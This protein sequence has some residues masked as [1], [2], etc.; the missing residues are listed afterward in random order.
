MF[1]D[2]RP[3]PLVCLPFQFYLKKF[4][5]FELLSIFQIV[6][7]FLILYNLAYSTYPDHN[8]FSS[9]LDLVLNKYFYSEHI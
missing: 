7:K 8:P 1:F 5:F 4:S 2:A 6:S 9:K 3:K